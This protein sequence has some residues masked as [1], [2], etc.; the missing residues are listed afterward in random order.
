MVR[1]QSRISTD[2]NSVRLAPDSESTGQAAK[3]AADPEEPSTPTQHA[4]MPSRP[5]SAGAGTKRKQP[6]GGQHQPWDQQPEVSHQ[7]RAPESAASAHQAPQDQPAGTAHASSSSQ[8]ATAS[9]TPIAAS[10]QAWNREAA[11][12]AAERSMAALK[13]GNAAQAVCPAPSHK[14]Q[15][16]WHCVH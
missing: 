3:A 15:T 5:R 8:T 4:E 11:Q 7:Q 12:E 1:R 9:G 2:A 16:V 13:A 6:A 14:L 10:M